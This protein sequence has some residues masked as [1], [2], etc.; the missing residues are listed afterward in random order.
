MFFGRT[1][2][3]LVKK[4]GNST[5]GLW[6]QVGDYEHMRDYHPRSDS[7]AGRF[8][9]SCGLIIADPSYNIR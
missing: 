9:G 3:V 1:V 5:K 4:G 2:Q 7:S 6:V 8:L